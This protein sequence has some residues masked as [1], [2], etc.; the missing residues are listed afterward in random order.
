MKNFG[1]LQ[2]AALE[3]L[4]HET[5]ARGHEL[6]RLKIDDVDLDNGRM[7][8]KRRPVGVSR[9]VFLTPSSAEALRRYL[10]DERPNIAGAATSNLLFVG[11]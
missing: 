11:E 9:V 1:S 10:R 7:T 6:A 8:V 2:R 5:A 3:S 4:L